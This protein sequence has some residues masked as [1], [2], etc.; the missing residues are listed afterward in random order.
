[1]KI[2][3][4]CSVP[5]CSKPYGAFSS[6]PFPEAKEAAEAATQSKSEFLAKMSHEIGTPMNAIIGMTRLALKT[7][8]TPKQEDYPSKIKAA[9]DALLRFINDILDLSKIE[10]G[11][12]PYEYDDM[13]RVTASVAVYASVWDVLNSNR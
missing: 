4:S 6:T 9:A 2:A 8:L 3:M 7:K 13:T 1:V 10:A 11:R 12:P 5:S